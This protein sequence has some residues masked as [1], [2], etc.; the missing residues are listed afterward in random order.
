LKITNA[1]DPI[2]EGTDGT[3]GR[4]ASLFLAG[5]AWPDGARNASH[6]IPAAPPKKRNIGYFH[7]S[8]TF[9]GG[10]QCV[11]PKARV[12]QIV[13]ALTHEAA[14]H[15]KTMIANVRAGVEH[16]RGAAP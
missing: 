8:N 10:H 6:C 3:D 11:S 13:L 5:V 2:V 12:N 9:H 14:T 4:I 7:I 1:E 15:I 16:I